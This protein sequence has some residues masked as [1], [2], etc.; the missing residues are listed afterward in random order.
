M[1]RA[2]SSAAALVDA[3]L[4]V[5]LRCVCGSGCVDA[6]VRTYM[7]ETTRWS[8]RL[9]HS[10]SSQRFGQSLPFGAGQ[11]LGPAPLLST[12]RDLKRARLS[13]L[14][15]TSGRHTG[16]EVS[17]SGI[18]GNEQSRGIPRNVPAGAGEVPAS[19]AASKG[20]ASG[21]EGEMGG[22]GWLREFGNG[23]MDITGLVLST[24][25]LMTAAAPLG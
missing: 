18:R 6:F 23:K 14:H 2:N 10:T 17:R 20:I 1:R 11:P 25:L 4:L 5:L 3:T 9:D 16:D 15:E 7:H 21:V 22:F 13:V 24:V 12:D 19:P 8:K